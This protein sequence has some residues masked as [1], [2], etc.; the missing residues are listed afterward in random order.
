M[1]VLNQN[2]S[3]MEYKCKE[4]WQCLRNGIFNT[5]EM[6]SLSRKPTYITDNGLGLYFFRWPF[7]LQITQI[8]QKMLQ[9]VHLASTLSVSLWVDLLIVVSIP[10]INSVLTP[11][12][13]LNP[14]KISAFGTLFQ[15]PFTLRIDSLHP[16]PSFL[17]VVLPCGTILLEVIFLKIQ[18]LQLSCFFHSSCSNFKETMYV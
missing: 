1:G 11:F 17:N 6:H 5:D 14:G 18:L 13:K 8:Y 10:L 3:S 16:P 9:H 15:I 4:S 7:T 12:C 2:F